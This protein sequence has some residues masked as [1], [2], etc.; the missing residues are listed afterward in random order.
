MTK[1]KHILFLPSWYP[2]KV[3]PTNGNFVQ[4]HAQSVS[5]LN[6]VTVIYAI[7]D[8]SK[9]DVLVEKN[10]E[11]LVNEIIIYIPKKNNII[12]K[13]LTFKKAYYNALKEIK[14]VD[15]V[16]INVIIPVARLALGI[17][18]A[19]NAPYIITEHSTIH[20]DSDKNNYSIFEKRVIKKALKNA[21]YLCPV[22]E[23][24]NNA[25]KREY[26]F[27][28]SKVIRNVV[29]ESVFFNID[30]NKSHD[31][32]KLLHVSSYNEE[33]KNI[34]GLIKTIKKLSESRSDFKLIMIGDGDITVP[35]KIKTSLNIS[36]DT[37]E[38]LGRQ[39][40]NEIAKKM[41]ESNLFVLFSNYENSPCVISEA[42]MCG[43]PVVSSNV[44]GINEMI[45]SKYGN[46]VIAKDEK[47]LLK[48]I[49]NT[50][51]NIGEYDK[52]Q[53]SEDAK[54][55]YSSEIISTQFN[56]IYEICLNQK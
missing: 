16:H 9:D 33:Q 39:N 3:H 25:L 35:E 56:E 32:K 24:L 14:S 49:S 34:S 22:S 29:D 47:A 17:I 44:G 13:Y 18:K 2:S 4:R 19:L 37:I 43:L 10:T 15:L 53:I 46:L 7:T 42:L 1:R 20:L 55:L 23:D 26:H 12:S 5:K 27:L 48:S 8:E 36:D 21:S 50:L 45:H 11:N 52:T 6:D 28:N 54:L 31:Q 40:S 38:I 51:D 41:Q 30:N